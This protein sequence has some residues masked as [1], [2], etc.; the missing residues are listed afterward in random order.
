M[1]FESLCKDRRFFMAVAAA[2]NYTW[3]ETEQNMSILASLEDL[4]TSLESAL[5]Q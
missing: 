4:M 3:D 2:T 5:S 1:D